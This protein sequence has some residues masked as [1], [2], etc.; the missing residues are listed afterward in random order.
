MLQ[1]FTLIIMRTRQIC[2]GYTN[3]HKQNDR[4]HRQQLT[5]HRILNETRKKLISTLPEDM[6]AL[7][8]ECCWVPWR[9][10][11]RPALC[12]SPFEVSGS[13]GIVQ[14]WTSTYRSHQR[15]GTL[16]QMPYL[17]Y[18]YEQVRETPSCLPPY[19][20]WS[21]LWIGCCN[22]HTCRLYR[23]GKRAMISRHSL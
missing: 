16:S 7:F 18:W 4:G 6:R 13:G 12:L 5:A 2:C 22:P 10:V 14:Q 3:D 11:H 21:N 20:S 19:C 1:I 8:A 23:D 9:Q 17:V 15:S